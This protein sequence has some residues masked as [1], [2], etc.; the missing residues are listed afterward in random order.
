MLDVTAHGRVNQPQEKPVDEGEHDEDMSPPTPTSE[1]DD[2]HEKEDMSL[3]V[4]SSPQV[5]QQ[6][7]S[8]PSEE[9]TI[10]SKISPQSLHLNS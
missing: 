10:S 6:W 8:S 2:P 5:G 1:P 4:F 9:N 3:H 7:P